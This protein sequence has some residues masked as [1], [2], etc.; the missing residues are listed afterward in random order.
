M[1]IATVSPHNQPRVLSKMRTTLDS[2]VAME[3]ALTQ[4]KYSERSF[5]GPNGA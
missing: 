3:I 2:Q 1:T 4:R 5:I